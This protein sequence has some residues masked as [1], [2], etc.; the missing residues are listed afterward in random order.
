MEI[1]SRNARGEAGLRRRQCGNE[2]GVVVSPDCYLK[3]EPAANAASFF[4]KCV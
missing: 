2:L 3:K 1:R 4:A